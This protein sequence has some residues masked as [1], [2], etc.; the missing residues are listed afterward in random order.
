MMMILLPPAHAVEDAELT[1]LQERA[2]YQ[3]FQLRIKRKLF[4]N[5]KKPSL[6][7]TPVLSF[8]VSGN[9]EVSNAQIYRSSG[10][11][12]IDE[13]AIEALKTLSPVE[14]PPVPKDHPIILDLS[15]EPWS[16]VSGQDAPNDAE[17]LST[18]GYVYEMVGFYFS[19]SLLVTSIA[20]L[21]IKRFSRAMGLSVIAIFLAVASLA[22]P[23]LIFMTAD[24]LNPNGVSWGTLVTLLRVL[25]FIL[26]ASIASLPVAVAYYRGK[27]SKEF[28]WIAGLAIA[29]LVLPL[30]W[31]AALFLAIKG[32][33]TK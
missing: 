16:L 13:S 8:Q 17:L 29:G 27:K 30:A 10:D 14:V 6:S 4:A 9:G 32:P 1:S 12:V 5:W 11:T 23:G 22:S 19:F 25:G 20:L 2:E 31:S 7:Q 24:A 21:F 33:K 3:A 15:V 26:F 18:I 28:A